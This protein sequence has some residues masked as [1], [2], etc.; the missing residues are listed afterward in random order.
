MLKPSFELRD[1]KVYPGKFNVNTVIR[2]GLAVDPHIGALEPYAENHVREVLV[3][4]GHADH[5]GDAAKLKRAAGVKVYAPRLEACMVEDPTINW[6]GLFGWA[7]PPG[8]IVTPY[9]HGEGVGVD[10]FSENL[11]S[12]VSLPGHTYAHTGYLLEDLGVMVAGDAVYPEEL[13]KRYGVLYHVDPDLMIQSL[14]ELK[15]LSWDYLVPGHGRV[16]ERWEALRTIEANIEALRSFNKVVYENIPS[17][18]GITECELVARIMRI[19]GMN[20]PRS[21]T[22]IGPAVR[23]H[24][25]SL[26]RRGLVEVYEENGYLLWR[27]KY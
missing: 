18:D 10:E 24:L 17:D 26:H 7:L 23:G 19:L 6:R 21:V 27:R 12:H 20:G 25:V 3:T 14:E 16:L 9:F 13:W 11:G 4:H 8:S 15:K 22:T 1:L 5:F 2:K